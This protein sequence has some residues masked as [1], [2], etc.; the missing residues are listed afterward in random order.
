M[1]H[2]LRLKEFWL[3]GGLDIYVTCVLSHS[4]PGARIIRRVTALAGL[5]LPRC[6]KYDV[7]GCARDRL[8][9]FRIIRR[10]LALAELTRLADLH[11]VKSSM[12]PVCR[13][14]KELSLQDATSNDLLASRTRGEW[15]EL[16]VPVL[17]FTFYVVG[18][19]RRLSGCL[20]LGLLHPP[21]ASENEARVMIKGLELSLLLGQGLQLENWSFIPVVGSSLCILRCVK[22]TCTG[23]QWTFQPRL[24]AI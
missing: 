12:S 6:E 24:K 1:R 4:P 18:W 9:K 23:E 8:C 15:N 7:I 3:L 10:R 21:T 19:T 14:S 11:P 20:A 13:L 22:G 5:S 2:E 16:S 17:H